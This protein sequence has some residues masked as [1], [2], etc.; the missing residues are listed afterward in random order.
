VGALSEMSSRELKDGRPGVLAYLSSSAPHQ[1]SPKYPTCPSI[2]YIAGR[3]PV[4]IISPQSTL[5]DKPPSTPSGPYDKVFNWR[6]GV[7]LYKHSL[8]PGKIGPQIT[9]L[10]VDTSQ[11][12]QLAG[13]RTIDDSTHNSARG[14]AARIDSVHQDFVNTLNNS[15]D[16]L[17]EAKIRL[18]QLYQPLGGEHTVHDFGSLVSTFEAESQQYIRE[19]RVKKG[20]PPDFRETR[21]MA[22][23]WVERN[24]P[25]NTTD[26]EEGGGQGL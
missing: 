18:T 8:N 25:R 7:T 21:G 16:K 17:E 4:E 9:H 15:V 6:V 13:L 12:D 2:A 23:Q 19:L 26:G 22:Y 5:Y 20:L 1:E 10:G 24:A 3:Y 14:F 11:K